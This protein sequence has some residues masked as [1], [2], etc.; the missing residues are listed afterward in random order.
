MAEHIILQKLHNAVA[1]FA[2][3]DFIPVGQRGI[4]D[5]S[6]VSDV[7]AGLLKDEK[8]CMIAR[9][10]SNELDLVCNYLSIVSHRD[11]L[12]QTVNYI[13]NRQ[14]PWWW[15]SQVKKHIFNEAGFFPVN[16]SHLTKFA[17]L[18]LQ[19]SK[20]LDVLGS[21]RTNERLLADYIP[22]NIVRINR[23]SI[24]PF[25]A[26]RPWTLQLAGKRV[27]VIHPFEETIKKQYR[28][29]DKLFPHPILPD[30][31]LLTFKSVQSVGGNCSFD[32]WF[33]ALHWM[34]DEIDKLDFDVALLG[35][36][37]YGFPLAAHIKQ[38][39]HIAI[40]IGGSLQLFFGIKGRR[41]ESANYVGTDHD[42]A[43]LYNDY[44]VRPSDDERPQTAALVE[45][46]C[47]W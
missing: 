3:N 26:K 36:G 30:F 39:G 18:M 38:T 11:R 12:L 28:V 25:F 27:L 20:Q 5:V 44:W 45:N 10:G 4:S 19:S 9:F 7:I 41:W 29:K 37:A 24:N 40:H 31:H 15:D 46:A 6:E 23:E 22:R 43:S 2:H 21:W 33:D 14:S 47:Y 16:E 1:H 35:C 17:Q 34:E 8:P 42:Y 32:T 13:L